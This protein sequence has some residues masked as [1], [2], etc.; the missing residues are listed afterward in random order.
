MC[1]GNQEMK[2]R[3][4]VPKSSW[5]KHVLESEVRRI[6]AKHTCDDVVIH[7][8]TDCKDY[9]QLEVEVRENFG[10]GKISFHRV[11]LT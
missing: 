5:L 11:I 8:L 9:T 10:H 4:L 1:A 6:L 2:T 3:T 7:Q